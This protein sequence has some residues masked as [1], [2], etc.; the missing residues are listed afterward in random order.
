MMRLYFND[1]YQQTTP[2]DIKLIG[3]ALT[4]K[5]DRAMLLFWVKTRKEL[6]K[7]LA[8]KLSIPFTPYKSNSSSNNTNR[9]KTKNTYRYQPFKNE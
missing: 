2:G 7:I 9:S 8:S 5:S 3:L 1:R 6:I 4:M